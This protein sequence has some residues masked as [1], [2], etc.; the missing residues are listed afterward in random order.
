[1]AEDVARS[2][3]ELSA[4]HHEEELRTRSATLV[5]TLT[6]ATQQGAAAAVPWNEIEFTHF[7][8][9]LVR[10][11]VRVDSRRPVLT[12]YVPRAPKLDARHKRAILSL[13]ITPVVLH[14]RDDAPGEKMRVQVAG[15]GWW[16]CISYDD[17]MT[18]PE[19]HSDDHIV[20]CWMDLL[21]QV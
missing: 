11:T 14:M 12:C 9:V 15:S 13:A 17:L 6:T 2:I 10:V 8:D 18:T 16:Q 3:V 19:L 1:M 5:I 4:R 7:D 21:L 20:S